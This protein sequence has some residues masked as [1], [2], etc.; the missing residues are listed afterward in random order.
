MVLNLQTKINIICNKKTF[1]YIFL[2]FGLSSMIFICSRPELKTYLFEILGNLHNYGYSS[3]FILFPMYILFN[4]PTF[5]PTNI[6]HITCG[7]IFGLAKGVIFS[8]LMYTVKYFNEKAKNMLEDTK[9]YSLLDI[10]EEKPFIIL[11]CCRIS[12]VVPGSLE[13]MLFGITNI[14]TYLYMLGTTIGITPQLIL[15]VYIGTIIQ[16]ITE[17]GEIKTILMFSVIIYKAN[18]IINQEKSYLPA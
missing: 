10:I 14:S 13:N 11:I 8:L 7:L 2:T 16:N 12:P 15:L 17:V 9:I 3:L 5:L 18:K 4:A 6:L 1:K